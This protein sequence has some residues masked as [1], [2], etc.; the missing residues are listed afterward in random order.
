M[1]ILILASALLYFVSGLPAKNYALLSAAGIAVSVLRR[2]GLINLLLLG[3]LAG[4]LHH[5]V[6][7]T[8]GA[9]VS[10]PIPIGAY[11]LMIDQ[12]R[13]GRLHLPTTPHPRLLALPN[14]HSPSARPGVPIHVDYALFKG[15]YFLYPG[16]LPT[17]L[18]GMPY[19]AVTGR[20][21]SEASYF[22]V[23]G[24]LFLFAAYGLTLALIRRLAQR[25]A[26]PVERL[27]VA[28]T[29]G[30]A[31]LL[32]PMAHRI[33]IVEAASVGGT[34]L[35]LA[36][37]LGVERGSRTDRSPPLR[38]GGFLIGLAV[39]TRA[40]AVFGSLIAAGFLRGRRQWLQFALGLAIPLELVAVYN[41]FRFGAPWEFG[42]RY[43][44]NHVDFLNYFDLQSLLYAIGAMLFQPAVEIPRSLQLAP[45]SFGAGWLA[46]RHR[47]LNEATVGLFFCVPFLLLFLPRMLRLFRER[48][49][50]FLDGFV[51]ASILIL[52]AV[53]TSGTSLRYTF[54]FAV[55]LVVAGLAWVL[56]RPAPGFIYRLAATAL[57][58]YS[59]NQGY[60]LSIPAQPAAVAAAAAPVAAVTPA[61]TSFHYTADYLMRY[62]ACGISRP[63]PRWK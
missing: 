20:Y 49:S 23:F 33:L 7:R 45:G 63:D 8:I 28:A 22:F 4:G 39:G 5:T 17:I 41:F 59:V 55:P 60:F 16:I 46:I 48:G 19:H 12:L 53:A 34:A 31:T 44:L 27:L 56:S 58:L 29:L 1:T 62:N 57:M 9:A 10:H 24:L 14:P 11:N 32:G 54:E 13:L 50:R 15:K 47:W 51:V 3:A 26:S 43:V 21:L 2:A 42:Y 30:T 38:W 36:G 6:Y 18:L 37:L 25:E 35:L 61:R 40:L 52:L